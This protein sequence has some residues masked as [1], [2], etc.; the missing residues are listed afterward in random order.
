M[1]LEVLDRHAHARAILTRALPPHGAP[2]HAYLFHGPAG[3]GKATAARA[4]AAELLAEGA[5]DEQRARERALRGTH[6]DLTWVRPSGATLMR[7]ADVDEPVV[8][9]A[10]RTPFEARR[11]VFV[12][13]RADLLGE[14]SPEAANRLLKTLE[15]P[16]AYAHLI[17][18]AERPGELLPT[19]LSRCQQVRFDAP[20]V[21]D[22][23]RRLAARVPA[24]Q[25]LACAR[26][27]LGDG[28]R[29]LALALGDGPALRAAAE[30]FARAAL[31]DELG[32]RPWEALVERAKELGAAAQRELEAR[33]AQEA[34]SLPDRE[35]RRAEREGAEAGKRAARGA[36][37][38]ALD[39]ALRLVGLWL[40]DVAC[41]VD[42]AEDVV[43]A[44]DRL[45]ALREDS[46][47][48]DVHRLRRGVEVV[49][50]TRSALR[51]N[52]GE[53]LA[54]EALGYRLARGLRR[55]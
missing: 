1:S 36:R 48:R 37:T 14:R 12:I 22:L 4:F 7:V 15:E 3:A 20:S 51:V 13:E 21:E 16:P 38:A 55:S 18:L 43:H 53:E 42:G 5:A 40:R 9:A 11:R 54:L 49:D 19:I 29:A 25:A 27:A 8:A 39:E 47:G 31:G 33:V 23:E 52:V 32:G 50:E 17:L 30:A 24:E 45:D 35:R 46:R 26:L 6:P 28:D 44:T 34:E 10:S 41:V 2:S